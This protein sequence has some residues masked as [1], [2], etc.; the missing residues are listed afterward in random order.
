MKT[1]LCI[2]QFLVCFFLLFSYRCNTSSNKNSEN[3]TFNSR[4]SLN[5]EGKE[6]TFDELKKKIENILGN[7]AYRNM[8]KSKDNICYGA[9]LL[10]ARLDNGFSIEQEESLLPF[11][12]KY[13]LG[14]SLDTIGPHDKELINVSQAHLRDKLEMPVISENGFLIFCKDPTINTS[15]QVISH[16]GYIKVTEGMSKF[17]HCNCPVL[18]IAILNNQYRN[19]L[20]K[21]DVS[22][23]S[24]SSISYYKLDDKF[25]SGLN[26][27]L[28]TERISV[29]Y[30]PISKLLSEC[31]P[32]SSVSL[33]G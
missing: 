8:S 10:A 30:C 9:A 24:N 15:K 2:L 4:F 17:Y 3:N 28:N 19:T 22:P 11:I 1:S 27:F 26:K 20:D 13:F 29:S 18:D 16:I 31:S 5:L 25:I 12:K 7:E 23:I 33:A 32:H 21:N 14:G 6:L